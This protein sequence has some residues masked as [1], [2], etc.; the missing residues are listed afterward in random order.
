MTRD[1][2]YFHA[3]DWDRLLGLLGMRSVEMNKERSVMEMDVTDKIRNFSGSV[4]GGSV[5]ALADTVAGY[6]CYSNLPDGAT[7]FTT[8]E[9]KCNFIG[10]ARAEKY[11]VL[12]FAYIAARQRRYGMQPSV[13]ATRTESSRNFDVRSLYSIPSPNNPSQ[14]NRNNSCLNKPLRI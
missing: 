12:P 13:M 2:T 3:T 14:N 4:H 8:L 5:V 10:M 11:V 1:L 7:G 6:G 9:L